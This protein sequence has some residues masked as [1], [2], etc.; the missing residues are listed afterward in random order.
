MVIKNVTN[1]SGLITGKKNTLFYALF[2]L[3][4]SDVLGTAQGCLVMECSL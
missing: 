3:N 1:I 2:I 4:I